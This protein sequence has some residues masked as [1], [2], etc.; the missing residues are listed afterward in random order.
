MNRKPWPSNYLMD[1]PTVWFFIVA[2]EQFGPYDSKEE[3][4]LQYKERTKK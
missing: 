2:G 1:K 3:A 4:D